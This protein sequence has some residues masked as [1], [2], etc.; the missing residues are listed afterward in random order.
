MVEEEKRYD[1]ANAPSLPF[2][3]KE[4]GNGATVVRRIRLD[5]SL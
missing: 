3:S 2:L 4:R 5:F 1:R